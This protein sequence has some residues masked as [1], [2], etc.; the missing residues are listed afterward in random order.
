MSSE[1]ATPATL[2]GDPP[3]AVG[4]IDAA[5]APT[6]LPED[7]AT[8]RWSPATRIAFRFAFCYFGL[9]CLCNGNAT[10]WQTIPVVGNNI[11]DIFA[12]VFSLPAQFLAGHLFHV[13]PP[14]DHFHPTGSGDT[15]II[16]IC[17]LLLLV[18]S[19]FATILWSVLDR[20]R[21]HYQTL[22]AW[23][24]FLIRLTL[25]FGMVTY[26]ID[27]VFPLQMSPPTIAALSEP[28]G[29]HSPMSLLWNFIG[30]NPLYEMICG[31]AELLAGVLL[32]FR[33]T[34]LAGAI[35]TAFVVFNVLAYNLFFDVPVK[36]YAGHLLLLSLFVILPDARALFRF[37]WQHQPAAPTGVWV[38][39]ASRT[40]FRR[41]TVAVEIVFAALA[42]GGDALG[43]T[44]GMIRRHHQDIAP[45]ALCGDWRID[46]ADFASP[47]GR[48]VQLPPRVSGQPATE[49]IV[50]NPSLAVLR[51]VT[52][53]VSYFPI[54]TDTAA[55]TI[56]FDTSHI[57]YF[58][59][60][61]DSSHLIL[62]PAG[63]AATTTA[64]L[65]L[66]LLTPPGGYPLLH[67]GF[68]WISEFPY[69][70]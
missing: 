2:S 35:F 54:K 38:P 20:R 28:L 66:T 34:A 13:P 37:F 8:H 44:F 29:M 12:R 9:Y 62:T 19:F 50:N 40:A 33:R 15:A 59:A 21:P 23:L 39:P 5:T 36:L 57:T 16:W 64:T 11:Q 26:G 7:A 32:L 67:R 6:S 53:D 24:R 45:C 42:I 47:T 17:V 63:A 49:F 70:R 14:G 27:K 58:A 4:A 22:A 10:I 52:G 56:T 18:V 1:D 43:A 51:D 60:T 69:Q 30:L 3:S 46:T 65:H 41:A 68:H 61:P 31:G 55:R 25:G 48:T